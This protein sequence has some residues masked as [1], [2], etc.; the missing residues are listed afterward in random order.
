MSDGL[1]FDP[2]DDPGYRAATRRADQQ[3]IAFTVARRDDRWTVIATHH[4]TGL[5]AE[6]SAAQLALA[7]W[8]ALDQLRP[9]VEAERELAQPRPVAAQRPHTRRILVPVELVIEAYDL[10]L[11][12]DE[13]GDPPDEHRVRAVVGGLRPIII[14]AAR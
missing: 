10:L 7:A 5:I 6:T 9:T 3:G 13:S 2:T 14:K 12:C 4:G 8:Q 11:A 1:G